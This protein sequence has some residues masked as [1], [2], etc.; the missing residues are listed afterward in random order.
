MRRFSLSRRTMREFLT[1]PSAVTSS[2]QNNFVSYNY[3]SLGRFLSNSEPG[4]ERKIISCS[5]FD[6]VRTIASETNSSKCVDTE[7]NVNYNRT[8][9]KES[10][11]HN[12]IIASQ[13]RHLDECSVYVHWPYC[14][15]LCSYCNFVKFVP[16]PGTSWTIDDDV[17]EQAMVSH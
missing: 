5:F 10:E 7:L 2:Q 9:N 15:K 16:K 1:L 11:H 12:D 17:I 3:S 13:V 8:I 6:K 14:S 4:L